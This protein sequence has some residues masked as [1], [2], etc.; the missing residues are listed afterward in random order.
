MNERII[1]IEKSDEIDILVAALKKTRADRVVFAIPSKAVFFESVFNAKILRQTAESLGKWIFVITK[2]KKNRAALDALGIASFE[3]LDE[4]SSTEIQRVFKKND[5]ENANSKSKKTPSKK[6]TRKFFVDKILK[7]EKKIVPDEKKI[8]WREIFFQPSKALLLTLSSLVVALFFFI[9]ALALPGATIFIKP[10]KKTIKIATNLMLVESEKLES[11]NRWQLKNVITGLP[12]NAE[13]KKTL[14]FQ[15]ISKEFSGKNARGKVKIFNTFNKTQRF[16]PQ[17][18]FQSDEGIVFRAQNWV[19]IPARGE[20][21]IEVVADEFDIFD[22]IVGARGNISKDA[23]LKI[24]GL[25]DAMQRKIYA[26]VAAD[27][28]GGETRW[29]PKIDRQDFAAA[30][31]MLEE[32]MH[33][34]AQKDLENYLREKNSFEFSALALVPENKYLQKE[35]FEIQIP[36]NLFGKNIADFEISGKIRVQSWAFDKNELLAVL[37]VQMQKSVDAEMQFEKID[38]TSIA[39]EVLQRETSEGLKVSVVANGIERYLIEPRTPAGIEFERKL[40]ASILGKKSSDAEN[41]L[42][43][44]KEIADAQISL[45]PFFVGKIPNLPENIAIQLWVD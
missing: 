18:R 43:N 36:E 13:F 33:D 20:A 34:E 8:N 21:E 23:K 1:F 25:S 30:Q 6:I 5:S 12:I 9:S 3:N 37:E 14:K 29:K 35:I 38:P 44:F 15:T 11:V 4:F 42:V 41:I 45:W 28:T 16:K 26:V 19:K 32:K 10:E 22:E 31:K 17:T 40:K 2:S 39:I 27:F 24:P 7:K